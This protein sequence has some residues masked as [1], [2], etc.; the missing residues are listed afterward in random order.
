MESNRKKIN[1]GKINDSIKKFVFTQEGLEKFEKNKNLS[2]EE[3]KESRKANIKE[4]IPTFIGSICILFVLTV[5][6]FYIW[7]YK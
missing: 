3:K 1:I 5:R 4:Y 7:K 6:L 2:K